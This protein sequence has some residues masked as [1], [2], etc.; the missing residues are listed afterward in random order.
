MDNT[1]SDVSYFIQS[2]EA[3]KDMTTVSFDQVKDC[4]DALNKII[5]NKANCVNFLYTINTDKLAFGC[6]VMPKFRGEEINTLLI[7]GD[8]IRFNEI[9][10][11]LDSKLFD[12]GMTAEQVAMIILYNVC[13]MVNDD[14]PCRRVREA[15]DT[16]L[17]NH[18]TQLIIKDSVQYQPIMTL[19]VC[20]A[21]VQYTNCLY[22]DSEIVSDP[23]LD[24]FGLEGFGETL[25]ILFREIPGA[26]NTVNR[27]PRLNMLDW[28][29]RLYSD[30]KKERIPA[31]KL[32][33]KCMDITGSTLYKHKF[34]S[35]INCLHRIDT[36]SY[37]QEAMQTF[38]TE[39]KK[40]NSL[41]SQIKYNGLRG[42]EEDFYEFMVRARNADTEDEVMYC[43]KQINVRLSILDDYLRNEE[44]SDR[45]RQ[46][47]QS[48]YDRY[49]AIRDEIAN[50]KVYNKRNYGIFVD[51]DKL[52]RMDDQNNDDSYDYR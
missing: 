32:L 12:Y 28:A 26:D 33:D 48:L 49:V 27:K 6:I 9:E 20:D 37:V 41:F 50:K 4:R 24:N 36:D 1:Y 43:L 22:L 17:M 25:N 42:I 31:L 35:V 47:W 16:Y 2:L 7:S 39:G 11:E 13:H 5:D 45:D 10:V 51:Y 29:L 3:L 46:R 15:I 18:D 19:G 21:L 8:P 30:V 34:Q 23:F 38:I 40:K 44:M 52:D 14:S